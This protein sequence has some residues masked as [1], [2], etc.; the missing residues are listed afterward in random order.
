MTKVSDLQDMN[1]TR[2]VGKW[3]PNKRGSKRHEM[4]L[5]T[6]DT[7]E[8]YICHKGEYENVLGHQTLDRERYSQDTGKTGDAFRHK[9]QTGFRPANIHM[10]KYLKVQGQ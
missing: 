5:E 10:R 2:S 8:A 1:L 9:L 6:Q 7:Y 4:Q 3:K